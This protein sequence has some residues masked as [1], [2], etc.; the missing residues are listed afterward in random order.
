LQRRRIA[1]VACNP[2]ERD[3]LERL[4]RYIARPALAAA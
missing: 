2:A 4:A 3:I 1:G